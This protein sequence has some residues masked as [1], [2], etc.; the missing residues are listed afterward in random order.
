MPIARQ[1]VAKHIPAEANEWKSRRS[2]AGQRRGKQA[3][4][5][6]QAVFSVGSVQSGYKRVEFRS[7]QLWKN[8]N[9]ENEKENGASL[10]QLLIVSYCVCD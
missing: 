7:W 2:T 1:R 3:L 10:R 8:G 4:S 5:E 9:E 6:I